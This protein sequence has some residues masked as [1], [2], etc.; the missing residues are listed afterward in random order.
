MQNVMQGNCF[1]F[2]KQKT[3][4]KKFSPEA[5]VNAKLQALVKKKITAD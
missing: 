2:V 4:A 1:V 5:G 3:R